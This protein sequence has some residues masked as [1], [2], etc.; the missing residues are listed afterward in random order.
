MAQLII[1][2]IADWS[3]LLPMATSLFSGITFGGDAGTLF[4]IGSSMSQTIRLAFKGKKTLTPQ[5]PLGI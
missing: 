5:S 1:T 3:L 2:S 4:A